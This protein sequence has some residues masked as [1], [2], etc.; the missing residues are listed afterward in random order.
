MV[1]G[2]PALG[3][4]IEG[5]GPGM[6][7]SLERSG[8]SAIMAARGEAAMGLK[9]L[10]HVVLKVRDLDRSE[11]F[12]TGVL[13]LVVTGRMP[14]RMVFF[15]V[16][17]SSDSHD[18]GLW[19]VGPDAAA[20]ASRQVGLFHVAWQV[21]REEDLRAFHDS[22]VARGVAVR[23]TMDHGA[24]LSVYFED[25]DGHMLEVTYEK[26]RETWPPGRNPFAGRDPLPFDVARH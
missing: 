25:P 12:Y 3:F 19:K 13:G 23:S 16:P 22:L 2:F 9:K 20:Q 17:G 21:E 5:P 7:G 15:A 14:G 10:G 6:Q 8:D 26:P 11:A 1:A 18:L 4:P 24:N